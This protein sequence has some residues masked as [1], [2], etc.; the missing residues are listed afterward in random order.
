MRVLFKKTL[1]ELNNLIEHME[2]LDVN[3]REVIVKLLQEAERKLV[4]ARRIYWRAV[5]GASCEKT[6]QP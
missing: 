2:A 6:G 3:E 5:L 1:D 4:E